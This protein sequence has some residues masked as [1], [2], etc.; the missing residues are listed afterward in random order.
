MRDQTGL[1]LHLQKRRDPNQDRSRDSVA[2]ILQASADLLMEQGVEKLTTRR[3]AAKAKVNIATLYQFYP[4]KQAIIYALYEDWIRVAKVVFQRADE[5]LETETEWRPFFIEFTS[6]LEDVGFSAEL[7]ARLTQ[8]VGV[9]EYL[10]DY[11]KEY[12]SWA[13]KKIIGYI[14]HFSDECSTERARAMAA[15]LLEWDMALVNL[16]VN[17]SKAVYK[18]ALNMTREGMLHLLEA[19]IENKSLQGGVSTNKR[20]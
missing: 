9:Y 19:C 15:I 7:E 16:E 13:T 18:Q 11:D 2:R 14:Q 8:A 5:K 20:S 4:N 12:L 6:G 3:I 17:N 10:R 1:P